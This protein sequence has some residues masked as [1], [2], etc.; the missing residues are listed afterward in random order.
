MIIRPRCT[1]VNWRTLES[2]GNYCACWGT[3]PTGVERLLIEA[4]RKA[5]GTANLRTETEEITV[6]AAKPGEGCDRWDRGER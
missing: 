2:A 4:A 1:W 6:R 5:N 3:Y